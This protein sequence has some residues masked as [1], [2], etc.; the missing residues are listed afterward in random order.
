MLDPKKTSR[1]WGREKD[2]LLLLTSGMRLTWSVEV[3][4][5]E[6]GV[7]DAQWW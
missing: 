6:L 3:I 7:K 5:V 2:Q 1:V 4:A